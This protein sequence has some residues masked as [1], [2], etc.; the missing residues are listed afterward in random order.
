MAAGYP[1]YYQ[2]PPFHHRQER[3]YKPVKHIVK[4]QRGAVVLDC[5]VPVQYLDKV[6]IQNQ[7]EVDFMRYTAVTCDPSVFQEK[8]TLRQTMMSR[9]TEIMI[10]ITMYNEDE[11]LLSRTLHGIMKN[12]SNLTKKTRSNTWGVDGWEKVVVCIIADGREKINKNVLDMLSVLG[13][14]QEGIA[15]ST[16]NNDPVHAHLYEYTTQVSVRPD[17]E[18]RGANDDIVPTQIIF[19][20]KEKNQRK[21]N[22]HRWFFQ[23]FCPIIQ[24]NVCILMDVGTRPGPNSIYHLWTPFDRHLNI[25]GACGE[26]RAMTGSGGMYLLNPLVAAQNFE[27]KISNIL[28]KPLESFLGYIQVLPGAFSA[29]RYQALLDDEE[30]EGPLKKYFMG[31]ISSVTDSNK[32]YVNEKGIFEA[33]MYLAEDRILC[34]ELV[35]KKHANWRLYYTSR[36]Y[37]ET[38]VPFTVAEFINQRRRW[39]NGSFFAGVY[40]LF[41]WGKLLKTNHTFARKIFLSLELIYLCMNWLFSWF[42]LA[43]FFLSFYILTGSLSSMDDPPFAHRTADIIH[44][45]LTYIY[46]VIMINLFLISMGNRPQGSQIAYGMIM[47]FFALLMI[48]V[49]FASVWIAYKSISTELQISQNAVNLLFNGPFR[50][51]VISA[52]STMGVFILS[53]VL[54]LDPWHLITSSFQ[55]LLLAPSYINILNTFAFCN[56][57]DVSWGTKNISETTSYLGHVQTKADETTAEVVLPEQKDVGLFYEEAITNIFSTKKNENNKIEID[58]KQKQED[59]YRSFRTRLVICWI[60]TNLILVVVICTVDSFGKLGDFNDRSN[61]YLAFILWS[62]AGLSCFRFIG[63]LCYRFSSLF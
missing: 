33:N 8:Y 53:G 38:D 51:I 4:I 60:F 9:R 3:R 45:V 15:K 50:D 32:K 46:A 47:V 21:I 40:S 56:T 55:Y 26:V 14:Y 29:Y 37:G 19:C 31:D 16:V 30:G 34:Y 13:V 58:P 20:L 63:S 23:A 25:A 52:S 43:N 24:P 1:Y 61:T 2:V 62:V 59:Y 22:S 11:I 39:L 57:H 27:Y 35:A 44:T 17:R 6:P 36:A 49:F 5:P 7:K 18:L 10:C 54:F 48:Y 41:H 42:A 28:D 12:I